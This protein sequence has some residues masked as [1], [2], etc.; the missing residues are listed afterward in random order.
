MNELEYE[1]ALARIDT[2]IDSDPPLDSPE[3]AEL[4]A[5]VEQVLAYE[6]EHF[7]FPAT[8]DAEIA[9]LLHTLR[10]C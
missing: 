8:R 6:K 1:A 3:G 7:P 10:G 4:D 2:L 5:L 9:E